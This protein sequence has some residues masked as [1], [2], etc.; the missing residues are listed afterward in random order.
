MATRTA[1]ASSSKSPAAPTPAVEHDISLGDFLDI[2]SSAAAFIGRLT[3]KWRARVG[4]K[5]KQTEH[6]K[7]IIPPKLPAGPFGRDEPEYGCQDT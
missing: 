4:E 7:G 2:L 1:R 3:G 5:A 6:R